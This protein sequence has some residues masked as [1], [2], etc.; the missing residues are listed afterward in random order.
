VGF[1]ITVG[2]SPAIS[3]CDCHGAPLA[4]TVVENSA[5]LTNPAL[6]NQA[7]LGRVFQECYTSSDSFLNVGNATP[8]LKDFSIPFNPNPDNG[9]CGEPIN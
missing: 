6:N 3:E 2:L 5:P 9:V 4:T 1:Q 8:A 7:P